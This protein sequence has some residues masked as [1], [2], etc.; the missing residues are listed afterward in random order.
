[1]IT[2]Q[3]RTE[4]PRAH[5]LLRR[6]AVDGTELEYEERG[7]GEPVLL[8]H[9]SI[10]ADAFA[11][12]LA[13]PALTERHHVVSYHRRGFAG[14][15]RPEGPVSIARQAADARA[16][17]RRLGIPRVHVV[18]HSYGGVIA[19]QLA[20][21]APD[22]VHSLALLEPALAAVPSGERS[23]AAATEA[24]A[25]RYQVGD[26][27]GAVDTFLRGVIGADG[28]AA[29]RRTIPGAFE[30]AVADLDIFF[31]TELPA[32]LAWRFGPE[33]ARRIGQPVLAVLG[34]G[35]DAVS[36]VFGEIHALLRAW[37]PQAEPFVLPGA[38]HA[39]EY[40]NPRGM[41]EGLAAFFARHPLRPP[42]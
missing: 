24:A 35:S 1:M 16:L 37:L 27:A 30:Q 8:I 19:L 38:T 12:L 26:R 20:L 11:P 22:T 23:V 29:A 7:S 4:Y 15:A 33:E 31:E 9:G 39:L 10:L 36:P 41:A 40:M 28:V 21:D 3:A 6:V 5:R 42:A 18:G 25:R 2:T 13:E 32:L 17:L 34:A 14:S